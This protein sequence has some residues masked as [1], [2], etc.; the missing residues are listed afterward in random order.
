MLLGVD[1]SK[2]SNG[3]LPSPREL[4]RQRVLHARGLG[5]PPQVVA[6]RDEEI[7]ALTFMSNLN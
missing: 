5:P 7:P 3:S 6:L 2:A 4:A 1:E